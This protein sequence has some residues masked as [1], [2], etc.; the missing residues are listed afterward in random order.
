MTSKRRVAAK[1]TER[2][3]LSKDDE[4]SIRREVRILQKFNNDR[5]VNI[6][7]FF[8]E[9]GKFITILELLEVCQRTASHRH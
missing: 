9:E 7:D 3:S 8:E 2:E 1:I 5:I 6:Y 4:E